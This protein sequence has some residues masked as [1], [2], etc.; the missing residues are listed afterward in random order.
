[1][2]N[3]TEKVNG[4]TLASLLHFVTGKPLSKCLSDP[5]TEISFEEYALLSR[6]LKLLQ[7]Q[8]PLSYIIGFREFFSRKFWVNANVLIPRQESELL[9]EVAVDSIVNDHIFLGKKKIRILELGTGSGAVI[10]S[11]VLELLKHGI[12]VNAHASD[13]CPNALS[14]AKNNA[15]WLGAN[16]SFFKGDWFDFYKKGWEKY[17]LIVVNPPYLGLSHDEYISKEN[18]CFEPKLALY[19]LDPSIDG[20]SNY[21]QIINGLSNK[22]SDH[23]LLIMEHGSMQKRQIRSLLKLHQLTNFKEIN[24]LSGLPRLVK[25]R[26]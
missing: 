4:K 9:V 20:M 8:I 12:K 14:L 23:S 15:R 25:V 7:K 3:I 17:D 21:R 16:I 1:M 24:D 2:V 26:L 22:T 10:I 13:I 18:L 11:I 5:K 19:G 6:C